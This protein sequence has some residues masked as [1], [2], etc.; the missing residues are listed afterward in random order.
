M[1]TPNNTLQQVVT[2]QR[3]GLAY[4]L[5]HSCFIPTCN[6]KFNNFQTFSGN[7]GDTVSYDLPYRLTSQNSLVGSPQGVVQRKRTLTVNQQRLV[8]WAFSNQQIIFNMNEESYMDYIGRGAMTQLSYQVESF[9]A[10]LA[11]TIPY[12][13]Y[14]D[15]VTTLSNITQV[16]QMLAQ[17]RAYG[18]AMDYD[19]KV[20]WPITTTPQIASSAQ[21][22]FVI[23]RNEDIA[24]KWLVSDWRGVEFY[25]SELLPTHTSGH[26]GNQ[27]GSSNVLTVVSTND[28]TG[29]N[30]T[31]ITFSGA[32]LRDPEAIYQ[33]DGFTFNDN[34][35]SLPNLRYLTF[36]GYIQNGLVPVQC[37]VVAPA[38]SDGAG[39]VTVNITPALCATPGNQNQNLTYNIVAGMQVTFLPSHI[40]GLIVGGNAMYLAMPQLPDQHPYVTSNE[41]DPLT[42]ISTRL[43]TGAIPGQNEITWWHDCI[44]GADAVPEYCMKIVIP[45][46]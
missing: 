10:A 20:Y 7:L 37:Q 39:N 42:G 34:V 32:A 14:G 44:F 26:V 27:I 41:K 38:G 6:P 35:G 11:E 29:N 23:S 18:S 33:Y 13:Y 12:R 17:Y 40:C 1:A 22:Q 46:T 24:N 2:Y 36:A 45:L 31:Q 8:P 5:F 3:A 21:N 28:P 15:G 16:A 4:L 30:I 19:L 43:Y 9:V 25:E